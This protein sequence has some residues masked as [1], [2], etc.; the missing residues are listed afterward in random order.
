MILIKK[1]MVI[2]PTTVSNSQKIMFM[3]EQIL[4]SWNV[5]LI[6]S[7]ISVSLVSKFLMLTKNK[8]RIFFLSIPQLEKLLVPKVSQAHK[9]KLL[10]ILDPNLS[11]NQQ[12]QRELRTARIRRVL[13][14]ILQL[15]KNQFQH[16]VQELQIN[17]STL[18]RDI[19]KRLKK[20]LKQYKNSLSKT[21]METSGLTQMFKLKISLTQQCFRESKKLTLIP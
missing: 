9:L 15:L 1:L 10:G 7:S 5:I 20:L 19:C 12:E 14:K 2:N 6:E 11:K 21:L 17:P 4:I 13:E 18:T 16:L 8:H 3:K